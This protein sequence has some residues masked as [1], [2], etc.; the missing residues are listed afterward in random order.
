MNQSS[1]ARLHSLV[2]TSP[3]GKG[4]KFIGKCILCGKENLTMG[5]MQEE[6]DNPLGQ[7]QG[8]A[9]TGVFDILGVKNK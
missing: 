4:Q 7:S 8:E 9:V 5:H 2:R 6:C 1:T 3:K